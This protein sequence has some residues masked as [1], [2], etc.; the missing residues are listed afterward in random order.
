[1]HCLFYLLWFVVEYVTLDP[2]FCFIHDESKA[3]NQMCYFGICILTVPPSLHCPI[4]LLPTQWILELCMLALVREATEAGTTCFSC[5]PHI[6]IYLRHLRLIQPRYFF[7]VAAKLTVLH[8]FVLNQLSIYYGSACFSS[9]DGTL[10][11]TWI[12]LSQWMSHPIGWRWGLPY[13]FGCW[14]CLL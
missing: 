3:S 1:M 9:P 13:T 10:A 8:E 14:W 7:S 2:C 5:M 12:C 6:P 4:L 11:H